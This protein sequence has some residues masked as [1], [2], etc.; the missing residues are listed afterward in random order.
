MAMRHN[1]NLLRGKE[2][3]VVIR[4]GILYR[5]TFVEAS[6]DTIH[7]KAMT[8]WVTIPMERVVSVD[9]PGGDKGSWRDR[10]IDPSFF[11]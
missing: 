11:R 6:E 9:E 7:L 5:G 2:V 8:G 3:E 4:G 1:L 10:D